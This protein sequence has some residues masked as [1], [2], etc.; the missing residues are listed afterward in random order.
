VD[1]LSKL[2][3]ELEVTEFDLGAFDDT[4]HGKYVADYLTAMYSQPKVTGFILWGFWQ[5]AHWRASD[6]GAMIRQDWT[7]RPA[8]TAWHDLVRRQWWTKY[9]SRTEANGLTKGRAFYGTLQVTV[10]VGGKTK[11]KTVQ[12]PVGKAGSVSIEF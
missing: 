12:L 11:V 2:G 6:G 4:F 10:Q 3:P 7:P 5:G 8:M 1:E 9:S